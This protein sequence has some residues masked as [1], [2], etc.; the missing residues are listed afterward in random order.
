MKYLMV[1]AGYT[2]DDS[3]KVLKKQNSERQGVNSIYVV[4]EDCTVVFRD[5][6]EQATAGDIV[7]TFYEK[8]FPKQMAV[9]K[10]EDWRK[11][12]EAYNEK[13]QKWLEAQAQKNSVI[14]EWSET[15]CNDC[16]KCAA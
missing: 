2:F 11:N 13:Q 7:V 3:T 1:D 6:A 8:D 15:C 14:N 16:C 10:S 9:V 5:H 4:K 12:I